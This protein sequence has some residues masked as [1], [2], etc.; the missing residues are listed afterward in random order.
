MH[1]CVFIICLT[2]LLEVSAKIYDAT[3]CTRIG[4]VTSAAFSPYINAP[5]AVPYI[6]KAFSKPGTDDMVK[7][8][9]ENKMHAAQVIK[10]PFV[11]TRTLPQN[12]RGFF[13]SP[14]SGDRRRV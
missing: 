8:M 12:S 1:T 9:N 2:Q 5:I 13:S 11:S 10:T 4:E 14:R 6:G 7:T 3:G